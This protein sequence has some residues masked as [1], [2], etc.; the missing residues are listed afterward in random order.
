MVR[1]VS[2]ISVLCM[3][4]IDCYHV[5]GGLL[6]Q[7]ALIMQKIPTDTPDGSFG[8]I[9][10]RYYYALG[11]C[12]VPHCARPSFIWQ[13]RGNLGRKSAWPKTI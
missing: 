4:G 12:Q 9:K 7:S 8:Q 2:R 11:F 6:S 1:G 13:D 3:S 10:R 5:M